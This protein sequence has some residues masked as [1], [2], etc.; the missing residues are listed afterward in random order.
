MIEKKGKENKRKKMWRFVETVI[1]LIPYQ[2]LYED[3][4]M[5]EVLN[6]SH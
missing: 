3:N 6:H 4:E 5:R 1:A 2:I